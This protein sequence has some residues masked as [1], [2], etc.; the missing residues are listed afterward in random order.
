[1]NFKGTKKFSKIIM[2]SLA[3]VSML[4]TMVFSNVEVAKAEEIIHTHI[5]ATKYD[6]DKHWEYCTVCSKVK[7]ECTHKFVD[8]WE[9]GYESCHKSNGLNFSTRICECGYS[10][11]YQKPHTENSTWYNTGVRLVHYKKCSVCNDWTRSGRCANSKGYLSCKNPGKCDTCGY[12]SNAN[13]HYLT[14]DGVCRDCGKKFFT[15]TEP[16]ITYDKDYKTATIKFTFKLADSSVTFTGNMGAYCGNANYTSNKW[17]YVKN[18]DGSMTYTG[19]YTFDSTKQRKSTLNFLDRSN[20]IKVNGNPVYVDAN[21]MKPVIWQD[22]TAPEVNEVRQVDQKTHNDWATIKELTI[23]GKENLSKIVTISILDKETKDV[24]VDKA[25]TEVT[26]GTYSYKCTPPLEG[27]K[28]GRSYIAKVEDE[29]GNVTEK[30]FVVFRTDCRAPLIRSSKEYT[31]W[32][33]TKNIALE[34]TDYGSGSPATSIN[35]QVSYKNAVVD[36]DK[37]KAVYT[38]AEDMYDVKEYSLY[39]RDGLGNATKETIKVGKVDNTK[40]TVTEIK[41]EVSDIKEETSAEQTTGSTTTEQNTT[42]S[43]VTESTTT[44]TGTTQDTTSTKKCSVVTVTAN[45]MNTKLNAEGSGVAG[46][47]VST[48]LEKPEADKWQTSNKLTITEKGKYYLWV[49]DGAENIAD[50]AVI[51]VKDDFTIEVADEKIEYKDNVKED[52]V[53]G[54]E[55]KVDDA[56]KESS[57]KTEEKMDNTPKTADASQIT[58]AVVLLVSSGIMLVAIRNK[59][60]KRV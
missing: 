55:V 9:F 1:M 23:S 4:G 48:T 33:Q 52:E 47:A 24:I 3:I 22:H 13:C 5:W 56:K 18:S 19:V 11:K 21:I 37:Y 50:I 40:P 34:L 16:T 36:G 44:A 2:M 27:P 45:D 30:E 7:D 32:S 14:K 38:F 35:D 43:T 20:V 42:S 29:I 41:G 49:K 12:V 46:Y 58:M 31:E 15:T 39:L 53:K 26:N 17:T 6:K 59:K 25:K 51:T 57:S 28:T 10:Y 8:H 60:R 54:T